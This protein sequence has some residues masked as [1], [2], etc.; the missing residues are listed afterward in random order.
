[1]GF[2]DIIT[3]TSPKRLTSETTFYNYILVVDAYLKYQN[4]MLCK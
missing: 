1:M 2:M 4:L 3:E